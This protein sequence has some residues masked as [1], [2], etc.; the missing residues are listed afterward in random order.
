MPTYIKE[1]AVA[2]RY[3]ISVHTLQKNRSLRK[4]FPFARL[5][6]SIIYCVEDIEEYIQQRRVC[7][8]QDGK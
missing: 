6:R 5:G 1:N 7:E 4:G 8:V 3:G 2:E